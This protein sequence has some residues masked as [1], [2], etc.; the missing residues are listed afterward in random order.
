MQDIE[1]TKDTPLIFITGIYDKNEYLKKGYTLGAIDYITK[2]IDM[3][4]LTA[5]LRVYIYL[6]ELKRKREEELILKDK[7]LIHQSKMATMGEMI[8]VIAHQ[9]KQPLTV[10]SL[11]CI[12]LKASYELEE[13]N[14]V[15]IDDFSKNTEEQIGFLSATIDGFKDFFS[16][17]KTKTI[18]P[19]KDC[20]SETLRLIEK[21]FI[22]HQIK[23]SFDV[24]N[25]NVFGVHTELVQVILNLFTN[26]R[27]AFIEKDIKNRMIKIS[28]GSTEGH[29]L[30][31][32]EDNAGG[33]K[34]ENIDKLFD[35]FFTTKEEGT[36]TG[37]YMV[38]LVV[39]ESFNGDLKI[40]NIEDGVKFIIALPNIES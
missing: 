4:I 40:L 28:S 36:G 11:S 6:F 32:I 20:I 5:K 14:D 23:I 31:V 35:P 39:K 10:L 3:E 13:I 22:V 2:P 9:L 30:L 16:P 15:F 18:F 37:L 27:D 26:A 8:G 24:E 19:L 38:S 1:R 33:V 12:N 7:I 29:T 21:Q 17:H 34:E 25:E